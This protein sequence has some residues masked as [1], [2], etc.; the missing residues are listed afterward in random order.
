MVLERIYHSM[1]TDFYHCDITRLLDHAC[2]NKEKH[3][4]SVSIRNE[5]TC[6]HVYTSERCVGG[7]W[8]DKNC[9]ITRIQFGYD[10]IGF[11][12]ADINEKLQQFV[13]EKLELK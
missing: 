6:I 13:G 12:G 9:V 5:K 3:Y 10:L 11:Y 8:T 2:E 4:L 7:I 1:Y